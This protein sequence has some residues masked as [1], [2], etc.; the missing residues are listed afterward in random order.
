MPGTELIDRLGINPLN[1]RDGGERERFEFAM[2]S[3]LPFLDAYLKE[4]RSA[5]AAMLQ[6]KSK[7][8]EKGIKIEIER[9]D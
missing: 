3:T 2:A 9:L 5:L 6:D 1:K 8:T 7:A 4:E